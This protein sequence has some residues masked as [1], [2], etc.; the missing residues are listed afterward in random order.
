MN[1]TVFL[2]FALLLLLPDVYIYVLFYSKRVKSLLSRILYFLPTVIFLSGGL[3]MV[4]K[5]RLFIGPEEKPII[6]MIFLSAMLFFILPKLLFM[7]I[8]MVDYPFRWIFRIRSRFFAWIGLISAC[9]V[10]IILT[11]GIFIQRDKLEIKRITL[12]S[13]TIPDSFSGFKIIQISDLHAGN[14]VDRENFVKK[15]VET[16]NAEQ[17]DMIA[18]TGD[19]VNIVA[20]ELIG[21]E[22]YLGQLKAKEGVYSIL[23]NHD[24]ADYKKWDSQIEKDANLLRL[25]QMQAEFGWLMLNNSAVLLRRN[26]DSIA[27]I[28]VENWGEPPFS[29][30]GDLNI[31]ERTVKDVPFKILLTHNPKHW[32]EEVVDDERDIFLTLSGH[33][34]AG[35]LKFDLDK[36]PISPAALRY[37]HWGG[38]S[39]ENNSYLYVNVG[40]GYVG[41]PFRFGALPEITVIEIE[42]RK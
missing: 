14:L 41:I 7:L 23:G 4:A 26:N 27:L 21:I 15:I 9:V 25:K 11:T 29:R 8:S 34:H 2:F 28:G 17:P 5:D 36:R 40:L 42:K 13:E 35:Q 33:T 3:L 16:V 39:C 38:L 20:D 37:E 1:W 6:S 31:A 12:Y 32:E 18:F 22:Q 10:I 24:Y 30:Y 19:L